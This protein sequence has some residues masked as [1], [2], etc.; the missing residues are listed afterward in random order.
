MKLNKNFKKSK[1][2]MKIPDG[3][4]LQNLGRTGNSSVM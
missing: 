3:Q 4:V 2:P 1:P